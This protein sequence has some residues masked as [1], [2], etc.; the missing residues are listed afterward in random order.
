MEK[1][2]SIKHKLFEKSSIKSKETNE[3]TIEKN[4]EIIDEN[5]AENISS[6]NT[7]LPENNAEINISENDEK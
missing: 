7:A 1:E 3:Q 2:F 4:E 5:I 6:Q